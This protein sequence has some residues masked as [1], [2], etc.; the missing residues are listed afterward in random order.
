MKLGRMLFWLACAAWAGAGVLSV[1]ASGTIRISGRDYVRAEDFAS[2][3]HL[4]TRWLKRD[5][6]LQLA[7]SG[8]RMTLNVDSSEATINGV[9]VRLLYPAAAHDGSVY[10]SQLDARNTFQP[11]LAP[12]HASAGTVI[13]RICLDPGH[14]GADPGYRV[15]S[16]QEKKYTLLLAQEL[17]D[18]LTKAGFRVT[19]TRTTD[20]KV[21]LD[22][23][24]ELAKKRGADLF[25][26]LHFNAAPGSASS[27]QGAEVYCLTPAGA[28]ST[29][30]RGE[31]SSSG[32]Y[33][34]N[35]S[36]DRNMMLAYQ[37][38]KSLTKG[39]G[40]EDRGVHRARFAVLREATMPAILIEGG[41][42]SHPSEGKKIF[43]AGYRQKL[44]HSIMDGLLA[45]KKTVEPK[46]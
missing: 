16:N 37:V 14:G 17:R 34:G 15:G 20:T 11:I 9:G 13:K 31:G 41:F 12:P 42:M 19:L 4:E 10:I 43:D 44:A 45:Y 38:Q 25:V 23:R 1:Q 6:E 28:P 5:E 35:R 24:A 46:N 39:L 40:V 33:P 29:N 36:N 8:T 3:N 18:Q 32:N 27:V 2:A 7:S 26:S 21:E 22:S 30:A